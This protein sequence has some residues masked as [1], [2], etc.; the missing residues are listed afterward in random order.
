MT[1]TVEKKRSP[2]PATE[3]ADVQNTPDRRNIRIDKVGVKNISY[4]IVVKDQAK[5][6]QHTVGTID[7][8]VDLPHGSR[9]PT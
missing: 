7:M 9:A 2:K 8:Y 5:G 1:T 6:T 3:L 4:P